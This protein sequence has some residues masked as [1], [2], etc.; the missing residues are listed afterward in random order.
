VLELTYTS[1]AMAPFARDLG[2][3]GPPFPWDPDRR[4]VLRAELD[5][6]FAYLYGLGRKQLRYIL[7]PADLTP[8]E[9]EDILDPAGEVEDP[10]DEEGYRRRRKA[11]DW[12]SETFRV[13]REKEEK[14]YGCYRTRRLVL[15]AWERFVA[16]GTFDLSRLRND[17][18]RIAPLLQQRIAELRQRVEE[19]AATHEPVLFVEGVSDIPI[20]EAAW[21]ALHPAEPLPVRLVPASGTQQM[22]SPAGRGRALR[23]PLGG[24]PVFALADNDHA[25]RELW[26][27]GHFRGGGRFVLHEN[28]IRWALL[29]PPAEFV[30]AMEA[31]GIP[32]AHWPLTVEQMF[33]PEVR[34]RAMRE[35]AYATGSAPF[36]DLLS[37]VGL[38]KRIVG[39][40]QELA[41]DDPRRLWLLE[42]DPAKKEAFA[43][44]LARRASE[45]PGIF[46]P[47][48]PLFGSL[49][50]E[51]ARETAEQA[52]A[53]DRRPAGL[54]FPQQ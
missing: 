44:W 8:K 28:G 2:Y 10:L 20:L 47:F 51:L 45:E 43:D 50:Q 40:L 6:Y 54:D 49:L 14:Q 15:E 3:D 52:A 29:P 21:R 23:E 41:P 32:K 27:N 9:L 4:A 39:L 5:A 31:F 33:T 1:H 22:R 42:P 24:R 36:T 35:G 19:F 38:G 46:E 16:D 11:S 37:D 26:E 7:D 13:L 48:R 18:K 34:L 12:P 53:G 25:G 30:A 17:P